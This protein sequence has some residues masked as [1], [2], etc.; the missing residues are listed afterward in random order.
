MFIID[1][2]VIYKVNSFELYKN[3]QK[4]IKK[5]KQQPTLK[6]VYINTQKSTL[7]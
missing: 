6:V 1:Y 5:Q 3:Q 7:F 2:T 4:K